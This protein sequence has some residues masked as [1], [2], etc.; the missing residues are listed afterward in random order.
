MYLR[1]MKDEQLVQRLLTHDIKPTAMRLLVLRALSEANQ[2]LSL[3]ELEEV[4]FPADRS[5]IF[6]TLT[7]FQEHGLVHCINDGTG[8]ARYE[9][10]K[11]ECHCTL[12]DQHIHF[13]CTC[14]NR[15]ICLNDIRVPSIIVPSGYVMMSVNYV[16]TGLCPVCARKNIVSKKKALL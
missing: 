5:T 2:I 8:S 11:G 15:T 7:L 13:H 3:K 9:I 16:V 4:L 14:C 6:R 12:E 10:C 1:S